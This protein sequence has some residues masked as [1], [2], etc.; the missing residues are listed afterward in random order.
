MG[1][2]ETILHDTIMVTT[3]HYTFVPPGSTYTT[4]SKPEC[5]LWILSDKYVL[6]YVH[7]CN[8]HTALVVEK[9]DMGD[10]MYFGVG[11]LEDVETLCTF[12]LIFV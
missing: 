10:A 7:Q 3:C 4:E 12:H 1:S 6:M 2:S 11:G 9:V 5:Q 8:V